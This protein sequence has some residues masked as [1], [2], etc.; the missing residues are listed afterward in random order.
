[1][2][3]IA[4]LKSKKKKG[5]QCKNK[6]LPGMKVCGLHK[7]YK[8]PIIYNITTTNMQNNITYNNDK[9]NNVV[10]ITN[11]GVT[12]YR[13]ELKQICDHLLTVEQPEQRSEKWYAVRKGILTASD[14]ATALTITKYVQ[15]LAECDIVAVKDKQKLGKCCNPYSSEKKLILKKC[16]HNDFKGNEATRHGQK[17]EPVATAVY[18]K[19]NNITVTEFGL[20]Q[21]PNI[22]TLGAS[23][24]GIECDG[25]NKRLPGRM[26][27]IKCPFRRE[28][29]GVPPVYYWIQMQ[30]QLEV[31]DLEICDFE[32]CKF[33]EYQTEEECINDKYDGDDDSLNSY[34]LHKGV[35]IECTKLNWISSTT[36]EIDEDDVLYIYPPIGT[37]QENNEWLK[38]NVDINLY[39]DRRIRKIWWGLAKY[40][41]TTVYRDRKWFEESKP[42]LDDFWENVLKHRVDGV[43]HLLPKKR[44]EF[45]TFIRTNS[46]VYLN[47]YTGINNDIDDEEEH[48]FI[49]R[50]DV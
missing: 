2:S 18:E 6:R 48:K 37:I 36:Y 11:N 40:S 16:G 23:P 9:N 10:S 47:K 49:I 25:N 4:T 3:C 7:K 50:K 46:N 12:R 17:Y 20:L 28:I 26:L 27:E 22:D 45:T 39:C 19:L 29:T 38:N 41:C 33:I 44:K 31:C 8:S 13:D 21:H 30:I 14:V 43:D 24:D 42:I 1:M 32:E 15:E 5:N 35:I 34:G